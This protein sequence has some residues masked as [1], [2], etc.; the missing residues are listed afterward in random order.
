MFK[1]GFTPE[2]NNNRLLHVKI[3][4]SQGDTPAIR[5]CRY[6]CHRIT[7]TLKNED[8]QLN[9]KGIERVRKKE[10]FKLA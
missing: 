4:L 2:Q 8:W 10:G 3:L 9:P 1:K 6:G 7:V 5:Y